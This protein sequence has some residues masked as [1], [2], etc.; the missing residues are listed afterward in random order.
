M[1]MIWGY[2]GLAAVGGLIAACWGQV[3]GV[4]AMLSSRVVVSFTTTG[5][6]SMD[7]VEYVARVNDEAQHPKI[8]RPIL[9]TLCK[10]PKFTR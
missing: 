1:H 9:C 8:L 5:L 2:A 3:R 6:A 7:M 4:W 10:F